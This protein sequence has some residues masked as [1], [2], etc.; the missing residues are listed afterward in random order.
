MLPAVFA[1]RLRGAAAAVLAASMLAALTAGATYAAPTADHRPASFGPA[2]ATADGTFTN[3]RGGCP[4]ATSFEDAFLFLARGDG[5][6]EIAQPST[7]DTVSGT[8]DAR[9]A[10]RLRSDRESYDGRVTGNTAKAAY[11]YTTAAGCT[12]T[13]D[14][15]FVLEPIP[16]STLDRIAARATCSPSKGVD[17]SRC[18]VRVT[19]AGTRPLVAATFA[20]PD[21]VLS[22]FAT[23]N[24]GRCSSDE[25]FGVCRWPN[26]IPPKQA[27]AVGVTATP[28]VA[29]AKT[30]SQVCASAE[31][32]LA[33]ST[34]VD[35]LIQAPRADLGLELFSAFEGRGVVRIRVVVTNHGPDTSPS[36]RFVLEYTPATRMRAVQG[37]MLCKGS[38]TRFGCPIGAL[39]P[40]ATYTRMLEY[41]LYAYAPAA[42]ALTTAGT[43]TGTV[44]DPRPANNR[45][46]SRAV[47]D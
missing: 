40:R 23:T 1:P 19:N 13:Y 35:A 39:Q 24:G 12:E 8:I 2:P 28:K 10:F 26:G 15:S 5:R 34:C 45:D 17:R 30:T 32:D 21:A 27:R 3:G 22:S 31:Q 46:T 9:G 33:P 7:G 38:R 36:A 42:S 18:T 14:A 6:M 44:A 20:I 11:S 43:V 29:V 37:A 4:V 16:A 25:G 41:G 47:R